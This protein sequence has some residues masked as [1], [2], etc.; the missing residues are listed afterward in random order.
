VSNESEKQYE[1]ER[2]R[3]LEEIR[4]RAEEAE[5]QRLDEEEKAMQED[6][7]SAP[8]S[9]ESFTPPE[10]N[11]PPP[12][13]F[14]PPQSSPLPPTD[15]Q[16]EVGDTSH[17]EALEEARRLYQNER[18][19][20]A[21][22][23]VE[24]V[25]TDFP[26]L[27]EASKLREDILRA[28][29]LAE[30]VRKEEARHRATKLEPLPPPPPPQ[31]VSSP[32]R[33]ESDFWGPTKVPSENDNLIP[34]VKEPIPSKPP[35]PPI[36]D[37][38]VAR[39]SRVRIPVKP[40]L[41]VSGALIAAVLIYIIVDSLIKAVAPPQ[42][43]LLMLP[44]APATA[45]EGELLLAEG[46]TEDIIQTIGRAPD[47]RVIAPASAFNSRTLSLRPQPLARNL[48]AG[49]VLTSSIQSLGGTMVWK[50]AL[51][52]T[53]EEAA[54]WRGS[55]ESSPSDF[56]VRRLELA[57]Q[58]VE[59]MQI[60]LPSTDDPLSTQSQ[61]IPLQSFGLYLQARG[62]TRSSAP[63]AL[64]RARELLQQVVQTDSNWGEGWAA[65]GW[66]AMLEMERTPGVP[67]TEAVNALTFIQRAIARGGARVAETFRVWGMIET[68]NA[69]YPKA[70]E[71]YRT[72]LD[73]CPGDAEALRRVAMMLTLRGSREEA[74]SA[75]SE[76]VQW[77]PLDPEALTMRGLVQQFYGDF[78]GA[79]QSYS[80]AKQV[81]R[82]RAERAA[83][84][85]TDCLVY[86]QRAGEALLAATDIAARRREDPVSHY[87]LGR[88]AQI[89]G[90]P[91]Q[92]WQ[93]L[94]RQ[95]LELIEQQL[96]TS[97]DDPAM[98]TLQAL[99]YTRLGQ[100]KNAL[101]A[102][103][104]ALRAAPNDLDVLYGTARMYALQRDQKQAAAFLS[105]AVDQRYDLG[106]VVD[107]DF[108]NVRADQDFLRAIS[109]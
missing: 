5:L 91:I 53:V 72:A 52:D 22:V 38:A 78:K 46:L 77:D 51:F 58:I 83:D 106:R 7:E 47:L 43:V 95:T 42:R 79:E 45:D 69:D 90:Q 2:E 75:A 26:G 20:K 19:E 35:P 89:A 94:F 92:E 32:D 60:D 81:A 37:R 49:F 57:R 62:L 109:R 12:P 55:L 44:A 70:I 15:S 97:P 9:E 88:V 80:R 82:G 40:I 39:L 108:F 68:F 105:L 101:E 28:Q 24:K 96:R 65:L 50:A 100:F 98:L 1:E 66:V 86:L 102:D 54:V 93:N 21:L 23:Q 3:L 29:L 71:R 64:P 61:T 18:Y 36:A 25:L 107:M 13:P 10:V 56:S 17:Q 67:R 14:P 87:R 41:I 48:K 11:P 33:P 73:L 84:L 104:R 85:H 6:A 99:T 8:I 74:L 59:A 16:P 63:N 34:A 4:R 76:A 27:R 30:V 103:A 31:P